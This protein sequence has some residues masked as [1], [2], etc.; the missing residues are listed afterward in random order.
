MYVQV[1]STKG[2]PLARFHMKR[3]CRGLTTHLCVVVV[4]HAG[5]V[6]IKTCLVYLFHALILECGFIWLC[7]KRFA[8]TPYVCYD[9]W[10]CTL[11]NANKAFFSLRSLG[12]GISA[13]MNLLCSVRW[14]H[15]LPWDWKS[16]LTNLL[17]LLH[18]LHYNLLWITA[19]KCIFVYTHV[20]HTW[21][22]AYSSICRPHLAVWNL[23]WQ[24]LRCVLK[25]L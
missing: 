2:V 11:P 15:W 6:Q 19:C 8:W 13:C 21:S 22:R 18:L 9:G 17:K 23:P 1:L 12:V 4:L 7:P 10:S 16:M 14:Q 25:R 5:L 20:L 24:Q 3:V